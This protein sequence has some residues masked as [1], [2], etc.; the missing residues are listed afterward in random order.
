MKMPKE[1]APNL[2]PTDATLRF[3]IEWLPREKVQKIND[4][5]KAEIANGASVW[6]FSAPEYLTVEREVSTEAAAWLHTRSVLPLDEMGEVHVFEQR[7]E[8][9]GSRKTWEITRR[10][11]VYEDDATFNWEAY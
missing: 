2:I 5:H 8:R 6:D 4:A 1:I 11:V 3:I 7:L 10:A 9:F